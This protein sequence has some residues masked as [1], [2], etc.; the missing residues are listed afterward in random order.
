[1]SYV[2]KFY[3]EQGDYL[4]YQSPNFSENNLQLIVIELDEV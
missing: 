3:R 2:K 4:N 1:M